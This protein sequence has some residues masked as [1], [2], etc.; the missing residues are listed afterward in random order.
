M[1]ATTRSAKLPRPAALFPSRKPASAPSPIQKRSLPEEDVVPTV[2]RQKAAKALKTTAAQP[3]SPSEPLKPFPDF[4]LVPA[5]TDPSRVIPANLSFDFEVAKSH[6]I[7][8]DSRFAQVFDTLRC[9]PY[10]D[11]EPVDPFR[12]VWLLDF[13]TFFVVPG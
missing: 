9:R 6:L 13:T 11:L 2:K 8:V 3:E 7:N 4:R 5:H 1:P 10:Q 12:L